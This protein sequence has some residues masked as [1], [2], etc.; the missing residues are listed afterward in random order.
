MNMQNMFRIQLI[1]QQCIFSCNSIHADIDT[2]CQGFQGCETI[3]RIDT[4]FKKEK[5]KP[6]EA[7]EFTKA[8]CY[9]LIFVPSTQ[10]NLY[11]QVLI[12]SISQYGHIW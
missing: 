1:F 9:G 7:K 6:T 11:V 10:K 3:Q 2:D 12:S 4:I 5:T 8:N